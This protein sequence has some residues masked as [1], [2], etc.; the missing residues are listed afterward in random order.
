MIPS[1]SKIKD[2]MAQIEV[3]E[4]KASLY[5]KI[6]DMNNDELKN[7]FTQKSNE[8]KDFFNKKSN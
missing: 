3:R 7:F 1:K 2:S 4:M 8:A 5:D 6:K